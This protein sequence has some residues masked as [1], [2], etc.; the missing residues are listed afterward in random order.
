MLKTLTTL[1]IAASA[2]DIDTA[3]EKVQRLDLDVPQIAAIQLGANV[4]SSTCW[5][6]AHCND[7][8]RLNFSSNEGASS[9][10]ARFNDK[11]QFL[12]VY[13]GG[14]RQL[15]TEVA[16]QGRAR[17][18]NQWVTEFDL[19]CT[20]DGETWTKIGNFKGNKDMETIVYNKLAKPEWCRAVRFVPLQWN[21]HIS[22]RAEVYY[23]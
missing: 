13:F 1:A 8:A 17:E 9:W 15:V 4:T 14:Q 10:C 12:Q 11:N 16:T 21:N 19:T 5:D 6:A 2:V 3:A 20:L 18:H 22:M 23:S 7:R